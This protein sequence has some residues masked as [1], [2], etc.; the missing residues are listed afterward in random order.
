MNNDE[1]K[2]L[3]FLSNEYFLG[4]KTNVMDDAEQKQAFILLTSIQA[5]NIAEGIVTKEYVEHIFNM[6]DSN[7]QL[8][9]YCKVTPISKYATIN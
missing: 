1:Q 5:N 6:F 2:V 8:Q 3:A 4:K 9:E 7:I